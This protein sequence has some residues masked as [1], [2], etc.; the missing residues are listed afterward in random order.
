MTDAI[1]YYCVYIYLFTGLLDTLLCLDSGGSGNNSS[2]GS[3]SSSSGGSSDANLSVHKYISEMH[4][5]LKPGNNRKEHLLS[6]HSMHC[7][8]GTSIVLI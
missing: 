4:R 7:I 1:I 6:H 8:L 5:V 3:S 2:S